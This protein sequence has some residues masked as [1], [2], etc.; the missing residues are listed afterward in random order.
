MN[1][2]RKRADNSQEKATMDRIWSA[3]SQF[4]NEI[5]RAGNFTNV[6][7]EHDAISDYCINLLTDIEMK[8]GVH[9][10]YM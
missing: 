1:H 5:D 10:D 6:D 7:D 2:N 3:F 9:D 4:Q 8:L